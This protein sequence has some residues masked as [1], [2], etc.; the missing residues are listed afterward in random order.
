[1][2][3]FQLLLFLLSLA[4]AAVARAQETEVEEEETAEIISVRAACCSITSVAARTGVVTARERSTGKTFRFAVK[5]RA[6]LRTLRTGQNV[7]ADFAA[8]TVSMTPAE[9]ALRS[10][11]LAGNPSVNPAGPAG[12]P[13]AA[14]PR[15]CCTILPEVRP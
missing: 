2:K 8:K 13:A 12:Q 3:R 6:L 5:D 4:G 7:W 10:A 11:E 15:L 9:P 14:T 1:M